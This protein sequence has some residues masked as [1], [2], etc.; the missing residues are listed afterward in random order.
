MDKIFHE[1][2]KMREGKL[3]H[4]H[5]KENRQSEAYRTLI[6]DIESYIDGLHREKGHHSIKPSHITKR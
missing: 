2:K 4:S 1:E 3:T 6:N 5:I